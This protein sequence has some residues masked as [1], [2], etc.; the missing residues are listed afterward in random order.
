MGK[1]VRRLLAVVV[2]LGLIA[3]GAYYWLFVESHVPGGGSYAI[4]LTEVRRLG[5]SVAGEKASEIRV[6]EISVLVQPAAVIVAGDGWDEQA[7]PVFSYQVVLPAGT[8]IIDTAMDAEAAKTINAKSFD[9][10]AYARMQAAMLNAAA[11]V[12]T[13]EHVDHIG[14]LAESKDLPLLLQAAKLTPEQVGDPAR[15]QFVSFPEGALK[16]YKAVSYERYLP[17]APGVVLIKSPGHTPG[18]QMVFVQTANGTE[19]LFLGDVA[20]SQRNVDLM[21]ERPRLVT[22]V[23]LQED[24]D[25]VHWQLQELNRLANA[26]PR[27]HLVPGHDGAAV[28]ALVKEGALTEKF[29]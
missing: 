18:S 26:E 9:A 29:R 8:V 7:M 19:Y 6:E 25:A 13:H 22:M 3:G 1:W 24:R 20:W 10:D 27:L 28:E 2:V 17:I 4:D 12:V 5:N 11:I 23:Y 14:G 21:R 15:L 16:D